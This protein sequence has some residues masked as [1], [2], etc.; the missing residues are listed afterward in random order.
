MCGKN[1]SQSDGML[2]FVITAFFYI[3]TSHAN[4]QFFIQTPRSVETL[5]FVA[6]QPYWG[7]GRIIVEVKRSHTASHTTLGRIP[8]DEGSVCR[9]GLH[10]QLTYKRPPGGIRTRNPGKRVGRVFTP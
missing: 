8:L 10:S 3:I 5:F 4:L 9:R 7:L 6:S 2:S 1:G